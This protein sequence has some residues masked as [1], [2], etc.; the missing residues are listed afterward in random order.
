MKSILFKPKLSFQ[1]PDPLGDGLREMIR[2]EQR[3]STRIN[4]YEDEADVG[5]FWHAF[6]LDEERLEFSGGVD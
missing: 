6:G 4:L 3:E 1:P 2:Q 5:R